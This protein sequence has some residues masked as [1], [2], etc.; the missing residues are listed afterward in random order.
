MI[1]SPDNSSLSVTK[2]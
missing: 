2:Y 1:G